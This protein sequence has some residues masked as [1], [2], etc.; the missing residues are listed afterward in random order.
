MAAEAVSFSRLIS[1]NFYV[2]YMFDQNII[3]HKLL[4]H[5]SA[6]DF[7]TTP[8]AVADVTDAVGIRDTTCE[9]FCVFEIVAVVLNG[10]SKLELIKNRHPH[11]LHLIHCDL[12]LLSL[13]TRRVYWDVVVCERHSEIAD[14]IADKRN[15]LNHTR[16][17]PCIQT[18]NNHGSEFM[19]KIRWLG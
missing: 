5:G 12:I 6:V 9:S 13:V 8:G 15:L 2:P 14:R 1:Y 3:L 11:S 10:S 4:I 16:L 17:I 19:L 18:Q 7:F